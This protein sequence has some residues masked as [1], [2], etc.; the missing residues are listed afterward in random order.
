MPSVEWGPE[1]ASVYDATYAYEAVP[2]V[3]DPMVDGLLELS[4]GGSALEFAVGTGRVALA[5]SARGVDVHGI[6]LS[7]HMLDRLR[8]KPGA[9]A[10]QAVLGDMTTHACPGR[11]RRSSTSWRTPS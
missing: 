6:E 8:A 7:S 2:D 4:E 10:V 9:D 11:V 5:L 3:V 1:I